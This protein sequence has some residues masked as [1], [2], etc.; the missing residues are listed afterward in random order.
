VEPFGAPKVFLNLARGAHK[1]GFGKPKRDVAMHYDGAI[2]LFVW[3][4]S[5]F[6]VHE[7]RTTG[8]RCPSAAFPSY[9]IKIG[10]ESDHV[11]AQK[12]IVDQPA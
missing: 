9:P 11:V 3:R 7:M 12:A 2:R 6:V 10:Q 4:R 8:A 5:Q 1:A